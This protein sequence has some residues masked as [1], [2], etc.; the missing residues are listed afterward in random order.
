MN[1][2]PSIGEQVWVCYDGKY[3]R[4]VDGTVLKNRGIAIEVEFKEWAKPN[5]PLIRS[6]FIRRGDMENTYA[7]WVKVKNSLMQKLFGAKG[8][9]YCVCQKEAKDD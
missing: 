2:N 7:A 3:G 9:Y 6:W 8:D 5:D 4:R 1:W